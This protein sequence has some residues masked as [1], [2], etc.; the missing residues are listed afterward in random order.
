ME[1]FDGDWEEVVVELEGESS[2]L[3]IPAQAHAKNAQTESS[4]YQVHPPS[5]VHKYSWTRIG[6]LQVTVPSTP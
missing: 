1:R 4:S 2:P 5:H 3:S 6:T